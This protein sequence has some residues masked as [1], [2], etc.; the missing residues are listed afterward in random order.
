MPQIKSAIKRV[1]Q[2]ETRTAQNKQ[3]LHRMRTAMKKFE[4]AVENNEEK[5]PELLQEATRQ[6]DKAAQ[7]K[8]IHK[9]KA[10]REKSRLASKL[11]D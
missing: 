4:N 11:K 2:E 7:K 3:F 6:L 1:R 10:N 8:I 5:A 9:N